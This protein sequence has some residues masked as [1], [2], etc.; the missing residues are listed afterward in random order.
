[1]P[2]LSDSF[3]EQKKNIM[4]VC[5]SLTRTHAQNVQMSHLLSKIPSYLP[6]YDTSA[7]HVWCRVCVWRASTSATTISL[8]VHKLCFYLDQMGVY[9]YL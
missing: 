5:K 4:W 7:A 8:V 1:M 2:T 6:I 9:F 3:S